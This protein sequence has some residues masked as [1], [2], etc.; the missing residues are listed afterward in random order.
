MNTSVAPIASSAVSSAVAPTHNS[1]AGHHI[2]DNIVRTT[3]R[4]W[5]SHPA[6]FWLK[7]SIIVSFLAGSSVPTPLYPLYQ[8]EWGFSP[9]TVTMKDSIRIENPMPG[10][11]VRTGAASAPARPASRQPAA[12]TSA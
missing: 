9:I 1:A 8:A 2:V 6:T 4:A 7:A 3:R 5:L 11:T 12:N 10:D